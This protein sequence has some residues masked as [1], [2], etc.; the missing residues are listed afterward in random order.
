MV[1]NMK[2]WLM[3]RRKAVK[4]QTFPGA[5]T[6]EMEIFIKPLINRNPQHLVLHC[7]TNDLAYKDPED[8]A[9]NIFRTLTI[10]PANFHLWSTHICRIKGCGGA[11]CPPHQ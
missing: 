4:V 3:S 5:N 2:G 10:T 9:R 11:G 6:D 7:G 8:V 1:R